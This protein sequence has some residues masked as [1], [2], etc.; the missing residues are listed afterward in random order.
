MN[1]H[2]SNPTTLVSCRDKSGVRDMDGRVSVHGLRVLMALCVSVGAFALASA[3]ALAARGHV[4]GSSFG[5][6]G[7]GEGEFSSPSGIAVN[8]MTGRVYVSD[9]GNNR[10]EYFS[11]AGAPEGQFNGSG[12]GLNEGQAAPTGQFAN[13]ESVAVDNSTSPSDPSKGDVYVVDTDHVVVDK[14]SPTGEYIGQI[15]GTAVTPAPDPLEGFKGVAVDR[16]GGLWIYYDQANEAGV[17]G[18]YAAGFTDEIANVLMPDGMHHLIQFGSFGEAE[19]GFAVDSKG[20]FYIRGKFE[21]EASARIKRVVKVDPQTGEALNREVGGAPADWVAVESST[22]DAYLGNGSSVARLDSAGGLVE[23]F[24][25]GHLTQAGGIAVDAASNTVYVAD[26]TSD[27][28]AIFALEPPG[29]PTIESESVSSISSGDA[30]FSGEINP[31]GAGTEYR[32]E[33]GRCATLT[34]CSTDG[35]ETRIPEP[36]GS[37]GSGFNV[38]SVSAHPGG[39]LPRTPYHFRLVAHNEHGVVDGEEKTFTTQPSGSGLVLPDGRAWELVSPIDARGAIPQQIGE[40]VVEQA[41]VGGD[42]FTYQVSAPNE[43]DPRGYGE[44]AGLQVLASRDAGGGWSSTDIGMSNSTPVG[45][46]VGDGHEYRFF[47]EDLST[48]I[49]EPSGAFTVQESGGVSE[50]F[51]AGTERTPYVRHNA[52]C[53]TDRARCY[54]PLVTGT[55][56]EGDVPS[57]TIF[58]G[59]PEDLQGKAKFVGA[60]RDGGHVVLDSG[61]QLTSI[62]TSEGLYEWSEAMPAPERLRLVSILPAAEGGEPGLHPSLGNESVNREGRGEIS[63]DGSR[64]LFSAGAP[65]QEHEHLYMR[66]MASGEGETVRLDVAEGGSSVSQVSAVLQVSNGD[67]TRVLF[68]DPAPLTANAGSSGNDLYE[69][70]MVEVAEVSGSKLKCDLSDLTPVPGSGAPGE[71]ESAVVQG[72]VLGASEDDGYVYFVANGVQAAGASPGDCGGGLSEGETCSLYVRHD[73]V[74]SFIATL[75]ERDNPDWGTTLSRETVRVSPDGE[76]LAFMSERSLTGYDNRDAKSGLPDE[77]VYLYNAVSNKLVCASC[78]PTGARPTGVEYAK[79]N[80]ELGGGDRVWELHQWLAADLPGWT[81]FTT[82]TAALHQPRY[83]SDEGRLFF[84][85]AGGLVPQDSNG[86]WDV[87]EYEPTGVGGVAGCSTGSVTFAEGEGGCVGL[88]SSGTALGESA[89][90]DAS[91]TG[92]DVFFLTTGDLVPGD[93]GTGIKVYDAHTCTSGLPCPPSPATSGVECVS[94]ASCRL[95]PMVQPSIY[96][97]PSSATFS[98]A[99]NVVTPPAAGSTKPVVKAKVLTRAQ[100]LARAL[101]AC[102]AKRAGRQRKVCERTARE[103]Y[104]PV[105]GKSA[106]AGAKK[107]AVKR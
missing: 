15:T 97:S 34:S 76:W 62:K 77:E 72:A 9:A 2:K 13:P 69:C 93:R 65:K 44:P 36:D 68:T 88:I 104:G 35:Y 42:A 107:G 67:G 53:Q 8:E 79:I 74:T 40:T 94:A 82:T 99:G 48:G 22:D 95:A 25:S 81:A 101:R 75:A 55:P 64:I 37:I 100:K 58:G 60:A 47:S 10:V 66:D 39:L 59:A 3:P 57:E 12:T 33:Y 14:F 50:E 105:K 87:Y 17:Q 19:P 83:L 52:T 85:S 89:F 46:R 45:I 71:G 103:R 63:D 11:A 49:A 18:K 24:G 80:D 73:G 5:K 98:G 90:M 102:K 91:A 96:G 21:F 78:D 16:E 4:F 28:V 23:R 92:G 54:E 32:F 86:N 41:A 29:A 30:V 20:D 27:D 7:S 56:E 106:R 31:R 1:T 38:A 84:N 70:N 26:S 43:A 51:P 6:Q 61:V